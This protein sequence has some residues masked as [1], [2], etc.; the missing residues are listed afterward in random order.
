MTRL[1]AFLESRIESRSV[2]TP[3]LLRRY[4][5]RAAATLALAACA[6][7]GFAQQAEL[8]RIPLTAGIHVVQAEVADSYETR[9]TG[10]MLRKAMAAN[11]GM[12]FVFPTAETQCMWMRNT[13][14]PLSVAFI[15]ANGVITNI[16]DMQ[17]QN[18]TSHCSSRPAPYAL[19]MNQGWFA[20]KGLKAGVKLGG[21]DK[22]PGPR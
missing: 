19:E 16:A 13:L 9:A 7:H 11:H 22:A 12:L 20:A 3:H 1:F 4:F 15:D 18:D 5:R 17:P 2:T 6:G 14:L 21:I 8:P 10:L